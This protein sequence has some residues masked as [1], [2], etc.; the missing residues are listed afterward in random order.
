MSIPR[1]KGTKRVDGVESV[2]IEVSTTIE[3]RNYAT[4]LE[5]STSMTPEQLD[6][7]KKRIIKGFVETHRKIK[8][9]GQDPNN[10]DLFADD[11]PD[12]E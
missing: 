5:I 1:P 4:E 6:R 3:G 8:E 7:V 9:S 12:E 2:I 10:F 11:E